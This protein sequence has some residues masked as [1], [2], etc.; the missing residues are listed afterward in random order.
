MKKIVFFGDSITDSH[1]NYDARHGTPDQWGDGY[2]KYVASELFMKYKFDLQCVNKGMSGNRITDLNNRVQQ[3]VLDLKPDFCFLM[4]GINDVWRHYDSKLTDTDQI[5]IV[6]FEQEYE[7]LISKLISANIKVLLSSCFYLE[8]NRNDKMRQQ[9]DDY[10]KVVE[11][12]AS[13]YD[14][15]YLDVQSKMDDYIKE[16]GSYFIS[17]DRV[18]INHLGSTYLGKLIYS[19]IED[20][21]GEEI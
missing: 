16:D 14:C 1:R 21:I 20:N 3:D 9:I 13:K 7:A 18:H 15:P 11:K 6:K 2:V 17:L 4:D 8:T 5:G 10:N 12:L 19:F